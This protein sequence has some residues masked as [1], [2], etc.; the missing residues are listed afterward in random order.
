MTNPEAINKR[1]AALDKWLDQQPIDPREEQAHLDNESLEQ[2]YWHYGYL[3]G[4]KD[5]MKALSS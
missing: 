3:M 2:L 5:T 4:L 1:I